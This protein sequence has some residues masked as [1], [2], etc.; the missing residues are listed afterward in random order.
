MAEGPGG[1]D[2]DQAFGSCKN[3]IRIKPF[4]RLNPTIQVVENSLPPVLQ[5]SKEYI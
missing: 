5:P 3:P 2:L 4:E 1:R